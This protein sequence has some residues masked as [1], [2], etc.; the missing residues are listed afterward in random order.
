MQLLEQGI[1][2]ASCIG[3]TALRDAIVSGEA[4]LTEHAIRERKAL[5]VV[6][7]GCDNASAAS[8]EEVRELGR[9]SQ[10]VLHAIGLLNEDDPSKADRGRKELDE[11]SAETGGLA[12]YPRASDE[13]GR[14]RARPRAPDPEPVHDRVQPGEPVAR[15]VVPEDP[16][17]GEGTRTPVRAHP[18]RLPGR[19]RR[20]RHEI[21]GQATLA[22]QAPTLGGKMEEKT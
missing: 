20:D 4:Y 2:H 12:Y 10:I 18:G 11:L 8:R 13:V 5:V 3:G 21:G 7:D 1:G 15:R 22:G 9:R 14:G 6:S 19:G 16:R 17:G